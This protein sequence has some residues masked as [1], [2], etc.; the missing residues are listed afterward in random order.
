MAGFKIDESNEALVARR[1]AR[2]KANRAHAK[3]A[4]RKG[5]A[6]ILDANVSDQAAI[7]EATRIRNLRLM[8]DEIAGNTSR[9]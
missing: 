6:G 1:D 4:K 8:Q 9:D 7:R 3:P 2:I 5:A